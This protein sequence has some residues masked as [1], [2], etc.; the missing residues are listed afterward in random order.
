M[1]AR[2]RAETALTVKW[3]ESDC[4]WARRVTSIICCIFGEKRRGNE[5]PIS[6]TDPFTGRVPLLFSDCIV[7]AYQP[8]RAFFALR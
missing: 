4:K 6:R 1:A 5:L 3:I 8:T 7:A 2:L